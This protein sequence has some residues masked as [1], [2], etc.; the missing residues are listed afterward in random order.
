MRALWRESHASS[1]IRAAFL[2]SI[3][4]ALASAAV[5]ALL[6]VVAGDPADASL[7]EIGAALG[8]PTWPTSLLVH[9]AT[10][11][12]FA[13]VWG[14]LVAFTAHHLAPLAGAFWGAL[15][16]VLVWMVWF[17]LVLPWFQPALAARTRAGLLWHVAWGVTLGACFHLARR[18]ERRRHQHSVAAPEEP[19]GGPAAPAGSAR[20]RR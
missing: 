13:L 5:L 15:Y 14:I 17:V 6:D 1:A 2:A 4:A 16:G 18:G 11:A 7:R 3:P 8:R 10:S 19:T 20:P 12:F 9:F